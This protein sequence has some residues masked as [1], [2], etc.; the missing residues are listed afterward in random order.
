MLAS[1]TCLVASETSYDGSRDKDVDLRQ[2][3]P[4][5]EGSE[6]GKNVGGLAEG[7]R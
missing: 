3:E 2:L 7:P 5:I 1:E 4:M 6:L